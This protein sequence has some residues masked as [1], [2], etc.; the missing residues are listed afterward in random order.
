M[1][2]CTA[3]P[4]ATGCGWPTPSLIIEVEQ[5][6]PCAPAATAKRSSSAAARPSAT[7]WARASAST[8]RAHE[9]CDCV[10]TNALIVDHWGIV[11]ADIGIKGGRIVAIGK[12]GNPDVQPGVDIVIGPG[13]E[14][15]AGEGLI[16]TAGGID[17]HIHF[18]CPQQIDEALLA[19]SPPCSA[20]APARPPAPWPP[21]ARR[22]PENMPPHAAGGRRLPDEP[23]LPRQGQ[24]QPARGPEPADRGR[25]HR[26]EAARGLGHHAGG[27]RQ[28]PDGGRGAPTCRSRSTP[29]RSTR[30]ASS[31][32]PSPPSRAAR[33]HTYHTEGAGGGHAP[34][35]M[36]RGAARPTCC[37]VSTN[38][39]RP[40]TVNTIDEHLDM[41]MVCHHLDAVASPRTW[42]SPRAASAARPSPPRTCCT[43]WARSA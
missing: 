1:P 30:A 2:R 33:I 29:T 25:R 3:P 35:I 7:A 39:T 37:P 10:I 34:D 36:Q 41:L 19:A 15:I 11:K 6:A 16:V 12:A 38:P 28:L 26:P 31:R 9:A 8:A 18:I 17:S 23:G 32:T 5:T 4:S 27:H 24:R 43:T 13:T 42:P 40:Y 22:G 21:P 14:I 20:A